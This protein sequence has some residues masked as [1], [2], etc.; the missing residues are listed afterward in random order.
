MTTESP[1]TTGPTVSTNIPLGNTAVFVIAGIVVLFLV[2]VAAIIVVVKR[3]TLRSHTT[4][5][6]NGAF[7]LSTYQGSQ[8]TSPYPGSQT[9]GSHHKTYP[10]SQA[11]SPY[12]GS[13]A[14]GS[15]NKYYTSQL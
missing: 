2:A 10:G 9:T 4:Q 7:M 11:T 13:Q 3:V 15:Y 6:N 1:A 5:D 8:A 14:T 12:P